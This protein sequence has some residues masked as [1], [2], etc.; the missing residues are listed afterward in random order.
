[1][2]LPDYFEKSYAAF[3]A[4]PNKLVDRTSYYGALNAQSLR[5]NKAVPSLL[6]ST[7]DKTDVVFRDFDEDGQRLCDTNWDRDDC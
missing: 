4:Y 2:Q 5:F 1:M 7:E 6:A 3:E